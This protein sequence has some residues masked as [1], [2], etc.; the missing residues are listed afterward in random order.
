MRW[1]DE[2]LAAGEKRKAVLGALN[3]MGTSHRQMIRKLGGRR[4]HMEPPELHHGPRILFL[5][6]SASPLKLT[7]RYPHFS[8]ISA[9][10]SFG[11]GRW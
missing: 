1:T 10:Y 4:S 6:F 11:S 3:K 7:D 5:L 8:C 2:M 9:F